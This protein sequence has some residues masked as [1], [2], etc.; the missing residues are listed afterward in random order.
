MKKFNSIIL[1]LLTVII[2]AGMVLS[3]SEQDGMGTFIINL[4]GSGAE[5]ALTPEQ[6]AELELSYEIILNGSSES[7]SVNA[8][9]GES[10]TLD[11]AAGTWNITVKVIHADY[12]EIGEQTKTQN[13]GRGRVT[14]V[15][16]NIPI[17]MPTYFIIKSSDNGDNISQESDNKYY[18][19]IF[20]ND[21]TIQTKADFLKY[22]NN[23]E[24]YGDFKKRVNGEPCFLLK[25]PNNKV[26]VGTDK[27]TV[28]LVRPEGNDILY[29]YVKSVD[30][31]NRNG[32]INYK[33]IAEN[34]LQ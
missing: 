11:V 1:F 9:Y 32:V 23:F 20:N 33:D 16:F 15:S 19:K 30:F 12:V 34:K 21:L 29:R 17:K 3:C 4:P 13:V 2:T 5:R 26:W 27:Y 6:D 14:P 25:N 24:A 8:T 28:V 10:V 31:I 18:V 7:R 22:E